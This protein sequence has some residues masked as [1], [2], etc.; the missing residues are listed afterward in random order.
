MWFGVVLQ[1]K[2]LFTAPAKQTVGQEDAENAKE[3]KKRNSATPAT[4]IV[5]QGFS[6]INHFD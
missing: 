6:R 5:G 1:Y 2:R 3:R 4:R